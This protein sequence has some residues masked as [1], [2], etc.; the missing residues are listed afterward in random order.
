MAKTR[1]FCP[2]CHAIVPA[3]QRCPCRK[4]KRK[5]TAGDATRQQ[6]EPWRSNYGD[7]EYQRN[8]QAAIERSKGRCVD[9]GET[10]AVHDGTKW[11]TAQYGGEVDHIVALEEGGTND[12]VNLALRCKSCHGL[13]D[14][15]R[16]REK[17]RNRR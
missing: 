11:R 16:R 15:A 3:G 4:A 6:R 13:R 10:V 12:A 2:Y 7:A 17:A 14:A 1:T 8:R 9:C 5:A